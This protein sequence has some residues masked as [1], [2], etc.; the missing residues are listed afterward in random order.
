VSLRSIL[1]GGAAACLLLVSGCGSTG[2]PGDAIAFVSTRDGDYAIYGMN[3]DGSDQGRLTKEH[4]DTSTPAGTTFQ[5]DPDFSP[6]GTKIAFASA[7]TGSLDVYVMGADGSST[8]PV[9]TTHGN[10]SE[11]T[12]SPDG[13]EIAYQSDQNGDHIYVVRADGAGARRLTSDL[14][15]EIEP[16]WSPDGRWIAYSRRLPGSEIREVWVVHP[17]GSGRR[18]LTAPAVAAYGPA[19]SP[20]GKVV[21]FSARRGTGHFEIYTIGGDG[22]GLRRVTYSTEDAFEPAWSPD[23]KTIAFSRGGSIV[24]IDPN[25][26]Q[27]QILTD[28]DDNDSSPDWNPR[29]TDGEEQS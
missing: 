18:R 12:W 23:G 6:D 19:W 11:P 13:S 21:A 4:G 5:I 29:P 16:A 15:P 24:T 7:R 2:P 10:Q 17:D 8:R 3:A 22:K 25:G 28:A 14:A 26:E 1:A 9:T 20:D 27:Q